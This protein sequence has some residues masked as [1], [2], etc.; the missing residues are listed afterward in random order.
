M[1]KFGG[2]NYIMGFVQY[3]TLTHVCIHVYLYK[4]MLKTTNWGKIQKHLGSHHTFT[5]SL[6]TTDHVSNSKTASVL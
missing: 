5:M 6:F 4:T 1:G 3:Y 2:Q